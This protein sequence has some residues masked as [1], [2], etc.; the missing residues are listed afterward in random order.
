MSETKSL[1]LSDVAPELMMDFKGSIPIPGVEGK[2]KVKFIHASVDII[3]TKTR[4]KKIHLTSNRGAE[5]IYLIKGGDDLHL[6]QR[7]QQ[8]IKLSNDITCSNL[9]TRYDIKSYYILPLG[10]K[11]GLIQWI[12]NCP[13][14]YHICLPDTV[15]ER[16][17]HRIYAKKM[18]ELGIDTQRSNIPKE[19]L[20]VALDQ[21][22]AEFDLGH[23]IC[24]E[25]ISIESHSYSKQRQY[26]ETLAISCMIGYILGLGDRHLQ[27]ILLD[28]ATCGLIHIDFGIC[29]EKGKRL[30]VPEVVPFRL[31]KMLENGLTPY[32]D[33]SSFAY[34]CRQSLQGIRSL[35]R[36]MF[37]L[38]QIPFRL[39]PIHEWNNLRSLTFSKILQETSIK[40]NLLKI[41]LGIS[42]Y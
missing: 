7:I 20:I 26:C 8:F 4:P 30:K 19:T 37:D 36:Y 18:A 23:V 9:K 42:S 24:K 14:L 21:L 16:N 31:T 5:Y 3:A 25:F 32:C 15:K 40:V 38:F 29:F 34:L 12:Q 1:S 41:Q 10:V 11:L 39:Q 27:N 17:P 22:E 13:S 28:E 2:E 33:L 6:D 35:A